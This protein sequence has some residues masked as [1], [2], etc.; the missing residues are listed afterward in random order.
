[1]YTYVEN[2]EDID[3]FLDG[4]VPAGSHPL[5]SAYLHIA[6]RKPLEKET[7][8]FENIGERGR[9]FNPALADKDSVE[10]IRQTRVWIEHALATKKP[11]VEHLDDA[12]RPDRLQQISSLADAQQRIDKDTKNDDV[13]A[14][15]SDAA[16]VLG[17]RQREGHI[18]IVQTLPNGNM[19][20]QLLT[21]NALEEES[22]LTGNCV[23]QGAYDKVIRQP[24][25]AIY[26]L[27]DALGKSHMTV[28]AHGTV[29]MQC[30]DKENAP[31]LGEHIQTVVDFIKENKLSLGPDLTK[32]CMI[33]QDGHYYS[34]REIPP[35]FLLE[36][37]FILRESRWLKKM[38]KNFST[39][40]H[41]IIANSDSIETLPENMA[42]GKVVTIDQCKSLIKISGHI[43]A[44]ENI[45]ITHNRQL[46]QIS[47]K[48]YAEK[49]IDIAHCEDLEFIIRGPVAG[50]DLAIYANG[51]ILN[52]SGKI[53]TGRNMRI[54]VCPSLQSIGSDIYVGKNLIIENCQ[55][56]FR[57]GENLHVEGDLTIKH[58]PKVKRIPEST[59]VNGKILWND[60]RFDTVADLNTALAERERMSNHPYPSGPS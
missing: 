25:G 38:P 14:Q 47:G 6:L 1:M 41:I 49:N 37:D 35:K 18:R 55:N 5:L 15:F 57:V 10:T 24:G 43:D 59:T 40:G 39:T 8:F 50:H 20:V 32:V 60:R 52:I 12:G 9:R 46:S 48:L 13:R 33:Y 26:S 16:T 22:T 42:A 44:K 34:L 36:G 3:R 54:A 58:C 21:K 51:R 31:P 53:H 17:R 28:E 30:R 23:G 2:P 11:W 29:M 45:F 7:A 27:R 19:W 56:F 4:F